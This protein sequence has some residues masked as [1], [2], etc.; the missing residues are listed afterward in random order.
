MHKTDKKL[1][2]AGR[3]A[4]LLLN[5][6]TDTLR[7]FL[8]E[9]LPRS[10]NCCESDLNKILQ[11]NKQ[12]FIKLRDNTESTKVINNEMFDI[13]FPE[14]GN[15]INVADLE[16]Q[17]IFVLIRFLCK[18]RS[19]SWDWW[20]V[21][22]RDHQTSPLYDVIRV[23]RFK[24]QIKSIVH[25]YD[26]TEEIF[27][28]KWCYITSILDK[29]EC[30]KLSARRW[31]DDVF[32]SD[33]VICVFTKLTETMRWH[34]LE[35][36]ERD[37]IY[38]NQ[39][40]SRILKL[41]EGCLN[42]ETFS[43][44]IGKF[45]QR[46]KYNLANL[47]N[48]KQLKM[49]DEKQET[50]RVISETE[51]GIAETLNSCLVKHNGQL[52]CKQ[53]A[54]HGRSEHQLLKCGISKICPVEIDDSVFI[55]A[56]REENE[57]VQSLQ[58]LFR[59][60]YI[61]RN[62]EVMPMASH[63]NIRV[64][65]DDVRIN[66]G[67]IGRSQNTTIIRDVPFYHPEI[68]TLES[69]RN[70]LNEEKPLRVLVEGEWS[71]GKTTMMRKIAHDWATINSTQLKD[72]QLVCYVDLS[73]VCV[74]EPYTSL[75]ECVVDQCETFQHSAY[76]YDDLEQHFIETNGAGTL[77]LLDGAERL[78]DVTTDAMSEICDVIIGERWRYMSVIMTTAL[79]SCNLIKSDLNQNVYHIINKSKY[80]WQ[81]YAMVTSL[82][83]DVIAR[84]RNYFQEDNEVANPE[85]CS[86]QFL[87]CLRIFQRDVYADVMVSPTLLYMLA[88]YWRTKQKEAK[89]T[90]PEKLSDVIHYIFKSHEISMDTFRREFFRKVLDRTLVGDSCNLFQ[91]KSLQER[92][93]SSLLE[94]PVF[95]KHQTGTQI[96]GIKFSHVLYENYVAARCLV[97]MC[98]DDT[99][100]CMKMLTSH[101][102][103]LS[104]VMRLRHFLIFCCYLNSDVGEIIVN[105]LSSLLETLKTSLEN[106]GKYESLQEAT[107]NIC[108]QCFHE[109]QTTPATT[110]FLATIQDSK[111][112]FSANK[113]HEQIDRID[114]RVL[115]LSD[116]RFLS[117]RTQQ[118]LL[119]LTSQCNPKLSRSGMV[120]YLLDS[121][122]FWIRCL[123]LHGAKG[124]QMFLISHILRNLPFVEEVHLTEVRNVTDANVDQLCEGIVR[125]SRHSIP[126]MHMFR[127]TLHAASQYHR[128]QI[129]SYSNLGKAIKCLIY[130]DKL[131][132]TIATTK[133]LLSLFQDK[134]IDSAID[135]D[136]SRA[137]PVVPIRKL[138][139]AMFG[140]SKDDCTELTNN[141]ERCIFIQDIDVSN[142]ELKSR[143]GWMCKKFSNFRCLQKLN[144][145]SACLTPSSVVQLAH[146][147]CRPEIANSLLHLDVSHN[148]VQC[149]DSMGEL[150]NTIKVLPRLEYLD[151]SNNYVGDTSACSLAHGLGVNG[152]VEILKLDWVQIGN[153]AF[154]ALRYHLADS[155]LKELS[156]EGNYLGCESNDCFIHYCEG[157]SANLA[158]KPSHG[159]A[160]ALGRFIDSAHNLESIDLRHVFLQTEH[161]ID[162][163]NRCT[164]HTK[165]KNLRISQS[166]CGLT[167]EE[168]SK[169]KCLKLVP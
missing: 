159:S 40:Q 155:N 66:V 82:N 47:N 146:A 23:V 114:G 84:V 158:T 94:G 85:V 124:Q 165:F 3:L 108:I 112:D 133:L 89:P 169:W 121:D 143:F 65:M 14:D 63:H 43:E 163:L 150:T 52:P 16:I 162:I 6:A 2:W 76:C 1:E 151:L 137:D 157:I 109:L 29:L 59:E 96:K 20:N 39:K 119:Y 15:E 51:L 99:G 68:N 50:S 91:V 36:S 69:W 75:S 161:L 21:E 64:K 79:C 101:I 156:L 25:D 72:F 77:L 81:R 167:E 117:Y 132:L 31:K 160:L 19:P 56:G 104:S 32:V 35:L 61:S 18:L 37:L 142:N 111:S 97:D 7:W 53:E 54:V 4:A 48:S 17:L 93:W 122:L 86:Q 164:H 147:L 33:D 13:L 8:L 45:G 92:D 136:Q 44:F 27:Q 34:T 128:C 78:H 100:L 70:M 30:Y 154:S 139:L 140:L 62:S 24:E 74:D 141:L 41:T 46:R 83:S 125:S 129:T 80:Q 134:N 166:L 10:G 130:L 11:E 149:K 9:N 105:Y 110:Q 148:N 116:V 42:V 118:S 71:S 87:N 138:N 49:L 131:E 135:G 145:S 5:D 152:A 22:P 168:A 12:L 60:F 38:L 73:T 55:G 144:V 107:K 28:S 95:L 67:K 120:R 102:S 113:K 57:N 103:C 127:F 98:K 123:N 126:A 106:S 88:H 153:V 115:K 90:L 58:A 26:I